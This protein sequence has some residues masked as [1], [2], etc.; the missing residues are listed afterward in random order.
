MSTKQLLD[1]DQPV[2]GEFQ[3]TN[4]TLEATEKPPGSDQKLLERISVS[5]A[6]MVGKPVIKGTR[7]T[8]EYVLNLLAHGATQGEIL[9]EY[10]GLCEEDIHACFL[11]ASRF[12]EKSGTLQ[13]RSEG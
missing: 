7:V 5:P 1:R 3:E 12:L 6:V 13:T 4:N 2:G 9:E 8:V 10:E 11:F